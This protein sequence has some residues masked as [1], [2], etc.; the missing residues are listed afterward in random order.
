MFYPS[1]PWLL[2]HYTMTQSWSLS[3]D[4]AAGY[5][6]PAW[7]ISTEFFFYIAYIGLVARQWWIALLI[8]LGSISVGFALPAAHGCFQSFGMVGDP[9]C[10]YMLFMFPPARLIEFIAGVAICRSSIRVPQAIGLAAAMAVFLVSIPKI[11][12]LLNFMIR[13][14]LLVI[15]GGAL[16]ASLRN[17]GWLA[18]VLSI[19]LFVIGG[20]VS[21]SIYLIHEPIQAVILPHLRGLGVLPTFI[22]VTSVILLVS[23][24]LFYLVESPSRDAVKRLLRRRPHQFRDPGAPLVVGLDGSG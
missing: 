24:A 15:A 19:P 5:N 16:I 13:E 17:D 7:S 22:L 4:I 9:Q 21:Y 6:G 10:S 11:D 1:L 3:G 12:V 18:R 2:F 20:E 23:T 14:V 8:A